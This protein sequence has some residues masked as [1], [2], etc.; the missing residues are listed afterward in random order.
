LAFIRDELVPSIEAKYNV[1]AGDRAWGGYSLGGLFG[2][3]ALLND[4]SPFQRFL[5]GSPS[6]LY[7]PMRANI[8]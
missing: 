1:S 4:G 5:I 8:T 2:L 3:Y 7:V 6:T